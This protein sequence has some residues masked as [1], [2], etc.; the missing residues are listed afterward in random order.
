MPGLIRGVT[1]TAVVAGTATAVSGRVARR[2]ASRCAD[3][4][5]QIYAQREAAYN[6]QMAAAQPPHQPAPDPAPPAPAPQTDRIS[7][8]KQLGDAPRAQR[9]LTSG[10]APPALVAQPVRVTR[11]D[12]LGRW[13][14]Q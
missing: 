13:P 14:G 8:L 9:L 10:Q 4:D 2:Q 3:K 12:T 1:R 11:A 6:Q 7:Q 5:A